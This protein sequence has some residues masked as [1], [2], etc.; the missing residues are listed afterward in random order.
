VHVIA[1]ETLSKRYFVG[2]RQHQQQATFRE[3][4]TREAKNFAR[5]AI[6]FG[7]RREILQGDEV[8]EF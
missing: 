7:N 4:L 5:K 6:D 2:H 8:E 1:A 3:M